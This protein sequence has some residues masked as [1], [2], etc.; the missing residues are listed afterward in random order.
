MQ[1]QTDLLILLGDEPIKNFLNEVA[2]VPYRSLEHYVS[3]YGYGKPT[4]TNICGK[5]IQVLPLAH[6][7]QIGGLGKHNERWR[8]EHSKW[9]KTIAAKT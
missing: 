3:Y 6:P 2:N 5:A 8:L 9:E 4:E 7:R 1:S